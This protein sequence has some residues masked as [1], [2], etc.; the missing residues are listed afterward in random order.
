MGLTGILQLIQKYCLDKTAYPFSSGP[1]RDDLNSV[2]AIWDK[3]ETMVV[4]VYRLTFPLSAYTASCLNSRNRLAQS[5]FDDVLRPPWQ[6][7][8][9]DQLI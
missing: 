5:R 1:L 9:S 3:I 7:Y 2:T 6:L 8:N 4:A